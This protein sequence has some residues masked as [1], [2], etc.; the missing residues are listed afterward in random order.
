M[1]AADVIL[2][3]LGA[4]SGAYARASAE[5][6]ANYRT[7]GTSLAELG[8]LPSLVQEKNDEVETK[9]VDDTFTSG[10]AS[11][12]HKTAMS[13]LAML[14]VKSARASARRLELVSKL[15]EAQ[16]KDELQKSTLGLRKLEAERNRRE[17]LSGTYFTGIMDPVDLPQN[18]KDLNAASWNNLP[19]QRPPNE[20][21]IRNR[22]KKAVFDGLKSGNMTPKEAGTFLQQYGLMDFREGEL[23][24]KE[25]DLTAKIQ[26]WKDQ[27]KALSD[28]L[29]QSLTMQREKFAHDEVMQNLRAASSMERTQVRASVQKYV[30]ELS[31]NDRMKA[32]D[33]KSQWDEVNAAIQI[34]HQQIALAGLADKD[35]ATKSASLNT[36][37]RAASARYDTAEREGEDEDK[38]Q[39]LK[40]L[41]K[42]QGQI[43]DLF[44]KPI[45]ELQGVKIP[46]V[47][48]LPDSGAFSGSEIRGSTDKPGEKKP[49]T[50]VDVNK[51]KRIIEL[52]GK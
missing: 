42:I 32:L 27:S 26:H 39:A 52:L 4:K 21:E 40:D 7:L 45:T 12:D 13:T 43:D 50:G 41:Q 33:E 20:D 11:G 18:E 17:M 16:S 24:M 44:S 23:D 29:A 30:A 5:R 10:L 34:A 38:A 31:H 48:D 28:K 47:P 51:I 25:K 49:G 6:Q 3:T 35:R 14:P 46:E 2:S 9:M 8:Q 1:G 37:L 15:E 19:T 22:V 36:Q